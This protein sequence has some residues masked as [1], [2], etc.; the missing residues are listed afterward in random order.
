VTEQE[1]LYEASAHGVEAVRAL[2]ARWGAAERERVGHVVR[3]RIID[4]MNAATR[5]TSELQL[6]VAPW[7]WRLDALRRAG[8][9]PG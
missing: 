5:A 9:S 3:V 8:V 4:E 6:D 7:L 1:E 2:A